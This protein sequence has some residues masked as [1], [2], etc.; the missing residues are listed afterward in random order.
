MDRADADIEACCDSVKKKLDCPPVLLQLPYLKEDKLAGV[1]DVL[2][3]HLVTYG[4]DGKQLE[5]AELTERSDLEIW[6]RAMEARRNIIDT[7]SG[8]ND[9]LAE[10]VIENDSLDKIS[11]DDVTTGIRKAT[12]SNVVVPVV[13]GSSYKNI[14]VQSLMDAI[15]MYL[16]SPKEQNGRFQCF[17]DSLCA[18]AFKVT[19][20]K[21]KGPLVFMRIYNGS[22]AKNQKIYNIQQDITEQNNRLYVAYA[23]EFKDVESVGDGNIAVVAGL[24]RVRSGDLVCSSSGACQKAKTK[25]LKS[26]GRKDDATID[27]LFGRGAKVPEPVFFC[28]IEPPSLAAQTALEQALE[29]LQREDPSLRVTHNEETGQTVLAGMGELHLEI[30]KD[31]IL[32]EYKVD[33]DLGPLQIAYWESPLERVTNKHTYET[34]IGTS[35]QSVTVSLSV[36]PVGNKEVKR[37]LRFDKSADASSNIAGI[38]PKHMVAIK[39]GVDVGLMHGPK[40]SSPVVNTEV[41]LHWFEAGRGTSSSMITATVT[42]LVQKLLRDSGSDILEPIMN[43]EVVVPDEYLSTILAD[44]S[45]RRT[46]VNNVFIRGNSK[47]VSAHCPLSELKGYSTILRTLSSGTATF[48]ME[49]LEYQKMSSVEEEK[50]VKEVRGF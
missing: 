40:I 16:P 35:K 7:I 46:S 47:V 48:T 30:I 45:R 13:L 36:N 42:Q 15:V 6:T 39:T 31:R 43:L 12:L 24:K 3:L 5:R 17:E 8:Y 33:A 28:S 1:I 34:K 37:V 14:G 20:D 50:A 38:H 21:Q 23:D 49:F 11:T 4:K 41:V 29:E 44:L 32:K 22:I 19:H 18:R 9:E 2:S 10:I 26:L 27:D 25:M